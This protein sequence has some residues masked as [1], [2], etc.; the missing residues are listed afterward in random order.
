MSCRQAKTAGQDFVDTKA[1]EWLSRMWVR[2][3]RDDLRDHRRACVPGRD[4]RRRKADEPA[5][6]AQH[7]RAPAIRDIPA[8]AARN[9]ARRLC[10]LAAVPCRTRAWPRRLGP[11]FDRLAALAS[12]LVYAA[13][14][15]LAVEIFGSGSSG[16]SNPKS[17]TAGVLG[18]AG[19][20][21]DRRRMRVRNDRRRAVPGLQRHHA[22]V[23]RGLED[24]GDEPTRPKWIGRIGTSGTR[25]GGRVR[26]RRSLP[27]QGGG[28]IRSEQGR[29]SRRGAGKGRAQSYGSVLLGIV[30][31]GS[32]RSP[33]TRSATPATEG[34]ERAP[35]STR[36]AAGRCTPSKA[37]P[38]AAHSAQIRRHHRRRLRGSA[39]NTHSTHRPADGQ[40]ATRR[41]A[42]ATRSRSSST[43]QRRCR[44][45]P[46]DALRARRTSTSPAGTSRPTSRSNATASPLVLRNLLAELPSGST[47]ACSCGPG[48]RC[49]SSVRR[50][51]TCASMRDALMRRHADPVRARREGTADALPPRE[52][53]RDRRPDRVRRRHRPHDRVGRPLRLEPPPAARQPS[54]GTTRARGSRGLRSRTSRSTSGC[55]G[56]R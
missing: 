36:P 12:G 50:A 47:C 16:S 31:A 24:R 42:P 28:R 15:V 5:R 35:R 41:R 43:A 39:G 13:L 33:S 30:A 4:R 21:M 20:A 55:G 9:R 1:F 25:T 38:R 56:T 18:L 32:S 45:S 23:P 8:H 10:A 26:A 19:R 46:S 34:S 6:R 53:D 29:G 27:D 49:R 2:G 40:P 11:G 48:H 14:C 54:A 17:S 37:G 22:K 44:R 7:H 51:E 52:D 3:A